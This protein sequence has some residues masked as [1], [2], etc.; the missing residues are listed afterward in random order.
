MVSD[1]AFPIQVNALGAHIA[2]YKAPE[3]CARCVTDNAW[4]CVGL[5]ACGL[6]LAIAI[7]NGIMEMKIKKLYGHHVSRLN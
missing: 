7:N 5:K 6:R 4:K 2:C 3:V 1:T